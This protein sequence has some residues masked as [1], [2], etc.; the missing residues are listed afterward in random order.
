MMDCEVSIGMKEAPAV[1]LCGRDII[2]GRREALL[3]K[4]EPTPTRHGEMNGRH[5]VHHGGV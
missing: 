3:E 2:L 5:D 4:G 1:R